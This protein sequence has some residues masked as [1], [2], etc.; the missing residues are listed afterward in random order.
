MRSRYSAFVLGR[1]DHIEKTEVPEIMPP[2]APQDGPDAQPN[3]PVWCGLDILSTTD[4]QEADTQGVVEFVAHY[5]HKGQEGTLHERS[6]FTKKNG[7]WLYQS[8]K[9]VAAVSAQIGRNDPCSCGSGKKYKKC[10]GA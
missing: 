10:C 7:A 9:Q 6:V 3:A 1:L 4:G 8:G 2:T 5:K